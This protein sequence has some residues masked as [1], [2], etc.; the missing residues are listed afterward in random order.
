MTEYSLT[1]ISKLSTY[2]ELLS[3]ELEMTKKF[4]ALENEE[5]NEAEALYYSEVSLRCSQ[6]MLEIAGKI[7]K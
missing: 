1:D 6:K 5:L 4:E 7:L 2:N 3:K